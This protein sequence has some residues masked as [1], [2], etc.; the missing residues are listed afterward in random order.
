MPEEKR[1][2]ILQKIK[3]AVVLTSEFDW[4]LVYQGFLGF[5]LTKRHI[6]EFSLATLVATANKWI[7]RIGLRACPPGLGEKEASK[8]GLVGVKG[9]KI[10]N[11]CKSSKKKE[12]VRRPKAVTIKNFQM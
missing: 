5:Y 7:C 12:K 6:L 2:H 9:I 1:V 11:Q 4:A 3:Q 10:D 8:M